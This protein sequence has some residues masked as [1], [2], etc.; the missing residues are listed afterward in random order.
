[1]LMTCIVK[2]LHVY[3]KHLLIVVSSHMCVAQQIA[4]LCQFTRLHCAKINQCVLLG[5]WQSSMVIP[6]CDFR[7]LIL[8]FAIWN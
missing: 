4:V 8:S 2:Q 3:E 5:L 7:R 6:Q 1:M